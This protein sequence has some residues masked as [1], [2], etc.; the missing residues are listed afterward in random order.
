VWNIGSG[1][2]DVSESVALLDPSTPHQ[3]TFTY[4]EADTGEQTISV[5][6][7]NSVS[8]QQVTLDVTVVWDNV[9]L[10]DLVCPDSI[11]WNHELTCDLTV[12]RFGT[13]ACF[14]WDMGD[15]SPLAGYR[16]GNCVVQPSDGVSFTEVILPIKRII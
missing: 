4:V 13:G 6:C 15:S 8:S 11:L 3:K 5:T 7:S 2:S 16:D 12:V 9:I 14:E 1:Y 10:G